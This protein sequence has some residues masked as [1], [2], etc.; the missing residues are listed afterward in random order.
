MAG[1]R[2]GVG[3]PMLVPLQ[4]RPPGGKEAAVGAGQV[5][6]DGLER[7]AA[8]LTEVGELPTAAT[9]AERRCV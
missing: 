6:M 2:C 7:L 9:A 8:Q 4:D 1:G 5:T 3:S